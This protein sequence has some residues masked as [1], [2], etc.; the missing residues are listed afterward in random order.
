MKY[1]ITFETESPASI[2]AAIKNLGEWGEL[3]PTSYLLESSQEVRNIIE[4]LQPLLGRSDAIWVFTVVAPWASHGD[5]IVEDHAY[6]LLGPFVD[7]SPKDWDDG[8]DCRH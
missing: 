6:A 8:A 1:L 7:W 2:V 3:T 5:P 4:Q